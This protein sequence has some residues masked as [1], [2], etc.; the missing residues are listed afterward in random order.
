[1]KLKL[2]T[3]LSVL[4]FSFLSCTVEDE[5]ECVNSFDCLPGFSCIDGVCV[6]PDGIISDADNTTLNDESIPDNDQ[7]DNSISNDSNT[8]DEETNDNSIPDQETVDE[9]VTDIENGD[10]TAIPDE[11]TDETTDETVDETTAD[12]NE[13]PDEMPD[14]TT[15]EN[16]AVTCSTLTCGSNAHCEDYTGT[17]ECVCDSFYQDEDNNGTCLETCILFDCNDMA[18]G[19]SN[20]CSIINGA[21]VCDCDY[22][23]GY[24]GTHCTECRS[25]YHVGGFG[26]EDEC[27]EDNCEEATDT[28]HGWLD[29]WGGQEC[30]DTFGYAECW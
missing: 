5:I 3:I 7:N 13:T 11:T 17:A 9:S 28:F 23:A 22:F 15:D 27:F 2:I 12:E 18:W 20:D 24:T 29:C 10:N 26:Y 16:T 30:R 21:P 1:M 6:D 14:E 19:A 8:P 4:S 25:G